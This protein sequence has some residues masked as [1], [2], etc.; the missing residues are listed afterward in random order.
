LTK[1]LLK[2]V[3]KGIYY[4]NILIVNLDLWLIAWMG[5]M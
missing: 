1:K 2:V 4:Y 5:R 3:K